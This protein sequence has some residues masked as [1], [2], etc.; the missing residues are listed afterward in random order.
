MALA[1]TVALAPA[2]HAGPVAAAEAGVNTGP[3][4]AQLAELT[5]PAEMI[6]Q[7]ARTAF[8]TQ[9]RAA[10]QR[11]PQAQAAMDKT[12]G[13]LDAIVGGASV[14]LDQVLA[15]LLVSLKADAGASF[16][17]SMD[18]AELREAVTFYQGPA[19]RK[20]V[21]QIP[22]LA[23]GRPL[24][25]LLTPGEIRDVAAF[26]KTSS[27]RKMEALK[28]QQMQAIGPAVNRAL[29]AGGPEIQAAAMAAGEAYMRTHRSKAR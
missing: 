6:R 21:A 4:A 7:S 27:S 23:A 16:A 9:F 5:L 12:P 11:N 3:L 15:T 28:P 1:L 13:L 24:Q 26:S 19:G 8:I 17:A 18:P 2:F 25:D 14:K 10:V 20:L 22:A 29:S